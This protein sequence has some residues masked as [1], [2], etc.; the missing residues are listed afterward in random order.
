MPRIDGI[1]GSHLT[2][3]GDRVAATVG[4]G[5]IRAGIARAS[6]WRAAKNDAIGFVRS[7]IE[8]FIG[9]HGSASIRETFRL[10]TVLTGSLNDFS[11]NDREIEAARLYLTVEPSEAGYVEL[12]P[13]LRLLEDEHPR[14]PA[15]FLPLFLGALNRWI[16]VYD[17]RDARE[18]VERLRDWYSADP[19]CESVDLP[20]VEAS[21]PA[22]LSERPLRPGELRALLPSLSAE[23]QGWT[24]RAVELERLSRRRTRPSL[25]EQLQDSVGD[26]N[27]PL[28][29]LLA[30]FTPGDNIEACFDA[31]AQSMMEVPPEPNLV[32]PVDA[33]N[34]A[35]IRRGFGIL[36]TVCDTL[37]AAAELMKMLPGNSGDK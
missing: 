29:S 4:A 14:L 3:Q 6:N 37:S 17:Y 18:H 35:G 27:P 21:V 7:E 28:P 26:C 23:V 15:T 33:T 16:R 20:D 25:S 11:S 36:A 10:H 5:L 19:D 8:A 34:P 22:C 32:I 9:Q 2:W 31:E 24:R 1:A 30:V 12:G 13:T